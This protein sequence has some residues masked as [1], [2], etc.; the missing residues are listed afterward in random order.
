MLT[1]ALKCASTSAIFFMICLSV[2]ANTSPSIGQQQKAEAKLKQHYSLAT[3]RNKCINF[4]KL[5]PDEFQA[6]RVHTFGEIGT[7]A[8][9]TLYY[10]IYCLVPDG[11]GNADECHP[12]ASTSISDNSIGVAVFI[13]DSSSGDN[14]RLLI[15]RVRHNNVLTGHFQK[16]EIVKNALGKILYLPIREDGTGDMNL[17]EYFLWNGKNWRPIEARF[18]LNDLSNRI[19]AQCEIR[20]GVW[21]NIL[22]MKATV[23]L[24]GKANGKYCPHAEYAHLRLSIRESKFVITS[25]SL[26]D[27][28]Q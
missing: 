5:A 10:A 22:T 15:D 28:Q 20:K 19:P 4:S 6:C 26:D 1:S 24:Y 11:R 8:K 16:P 3:V 18:W 17:S 25:I 27:Q 12:G 9:K 14:V 2:Q 23:Q 13:R 7:V 21:P